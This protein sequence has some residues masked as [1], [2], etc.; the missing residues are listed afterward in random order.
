MKNIAIEGMLLTSIDA[1]DV[2]I[3]Q[4]KIGRKEYRTALSQLEKARTMNS[5][6]G[7]D[8]NSAIDAE[9]TK[10]KS[11]LE[12]SDRELRKLKLIKYRLNS[13]LNILND[14]PEEVEESDI[15]LIKES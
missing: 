14:N 1:I 7:I 10:V 5:K 12:E 6:I 15:S 9:I 11:S 4:M 8:V 2:E 3:E 13:S